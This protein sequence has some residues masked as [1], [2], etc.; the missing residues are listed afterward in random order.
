MQGVLGLQNLALLLLELRVLDVELFLAFEK[1]LERPLVVVLRLE[2]RPGIVDARVV[3]DIHT[4]LQIMVLALHQVFRLVGLV[5]QAVNIGTLPRL[6][7]QILLLVGLGAIL[8]FVLEL[9]QLDQASLF[10]QLVL[11]VLNLQLR[12]ELLL[13]S[14]FLDLGFLE[15]LE[16]EVDVLESLLFL[17]VLANACVA[18]RGLDV[19]RSGEH[20]SGAVRNNHVILEGVVRRRRP[21]VPLAVD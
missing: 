5:F 14:A 3:G 9:R 17:H 19:N 7:I 4:F 20:L 18:H 8:N 12:L 2:I 1:C 21:T 11:K 16:V 15:I 6:F 10:V 13:Q